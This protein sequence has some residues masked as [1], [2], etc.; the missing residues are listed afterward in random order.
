MKFTMGGSSIF[1]GTAHF[2]CP[3]RRLDNDLSHL[4][5]EIIAGAM[6]RICRCDGDMWRVMRVELK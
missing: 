6:K 1:A 4:P 3:F 5:P 2:V